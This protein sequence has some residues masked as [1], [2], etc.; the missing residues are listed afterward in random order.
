MLDT[1]VALKNFLADRPEWAFLSLSLVVNSI[2]FRL[3]L[4]E[5][6]NH[7]QTVMQVVPLGEKLHEM[8][9]IVVQR[10]QRGGTPK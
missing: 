1:L 5:K 6:D 3:L 10:R 8:L 7:L 4:K 2:L 9:Q